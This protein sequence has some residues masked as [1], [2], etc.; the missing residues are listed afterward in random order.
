MKAQND[1]FSNLE[2]IKKG[3]TDGVFKLL[4]VVNKNDVTRDAF[5]DTAYEDIKT[6]ILEYLK[7]ENNSEQDIDKLCLTMA[8]NA[9]ELTAIL[10]DT[11]YF[12]LEDRLKEKKKQIEEHLAS[13]QKSFYTVQEVIGMSDIFNIKTPNTLI[14]KLGLGEIRAKKINGQWQIPRES[15]IEFVGHDKF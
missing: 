11:Y 7:R 6:C 2:F 10:Y 4:D 8:Q 12:L 9:R 14:K 15:L 5:E 3:F 13:S 1:D